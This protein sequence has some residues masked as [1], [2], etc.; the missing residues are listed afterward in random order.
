MYERATYAVLTNHPGIWD[1]A[2]KGA[3]SVV[4]FVEMKQWGNVDGN[5]GALAFSLQLYQKLIDQKSSKNRKLEEL[6]IGATGELDQSGQV[7]P[8]EGVTEKLR[9]FLNVILKKPESHPFPVFMFP[10]KME[11]GLSDNKEFKE[12]ISVL[13]NDLG[14]VCHPVQTL[15]DALF[16]LLGKEDYPLN[17]ISTSP[18]KGLDAFRYA[19]RHQFFGRE[20]QINSQIEVMREY[21]EVDNSKLHLIV[22]GESGTGKSSFVQAGLLAPLMAE[23]GIRNSIYL[24][25][26]PGDLKGKL[27]QFFV[28]GLRGFLPSIDETRYHYSE[29]IDNTAQTIDSFMKYIQPIE[30]P[31]KRLVIVIDQLEEVVTDESIH[32]NPSELAAFSK[33]IRGFS[34]Y[35]SLNRSQSQAPLCWV[36]STV[37]SSEYDKA[38][39]LL[40]L[41]EDRNQYIGFH[42]SIPDKNN[43]Q[44]Y[45]DIIV[46]PARQS[47]ISIEGKL[48]DNLMPAVR[49]VGNIL[50]LLEYVLDQLFIVTVNKEKLS[51]G[52]TWALFNSELES[53]SGLIKNNSQALYDSFD[54]IQKE[55]FNTEF[56]PKLVGVDDHRTVVYPISTARKEFST[57]LQLNRIL[58]KFEEKRLVSISNGNVRFSHEV[59][60]REWSHISEW[61]ESIRIKN[62]LNIRIAAEKKVSAAKRS[63]RRAYAAASATLLLFILAGAF[64]YIFNI[65]TIREKDNISSASIQAELFSNI[66]PIGLS[67]DIIKGIKYEFGTMPIDQE[68]VLKYESILDESDPVR[69]IKES[70]IRNIIEPAEI[71]AREQIS[72]SPTTA[73]NSLIMIAKAYTRWGDY[74]SA[75][76]ALQESIRIQMT[77]PNFDNETLLD[78][79]VV[80]KFG[81]SLVGIPV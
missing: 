48:V 17:D 9:A 72:D 67:A 42:L 8:V 56:L 73:S 57:N 58:N 75:T 6:S 69:I 22:Y 65:S 38:K 30:G 71:N 26:K 52:L 19:D 2:K 62:D 64:L 12:S 25:I 68:L 49:D 53:I 23:E 41:D 63:T 4:G 16:L 61:A 21:S 46:R 60:L 81:H 37:R 59:L 35:H 50:P 78:S 28:D 45:R 34:E 15:T 32:N 80:K 20:D 13:E 74:E 18:Y 10:S 79:V 40:N 24:V 33:I 76:S 31:P 27:V 77:N 5:S 66:D 29:W 43:P 36:I 51:E 7:L 1:Q 70:L 3:L 39:Q 11:N 54:S 44:Y 14:G 55:M 47:G